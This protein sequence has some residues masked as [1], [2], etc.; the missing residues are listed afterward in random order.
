MTGIT[1]LI[2][3]EAFK[4]AVSRALGW[5]AS[6]AGV[7]ATWAGGGPAAG[8]GAG[9]EQV[10]GGP[11]PLRARANKGSARPGSASMKN[12]FISGGSDGLLLL[13]GRDISCGEAC[14]GC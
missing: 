6:S 8:P 4:A 7:G 1:S 11:A 3:I 10:L 13:P 9:S 14:I 2:L 5:R 12:C